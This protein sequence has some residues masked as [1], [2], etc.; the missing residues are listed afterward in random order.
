[1]ILETLTFRDPAQ[2]SLDDGERWSTSRIDP[3]RLLM[4]TRSFEA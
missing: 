4:N 1:M 3:N 2:R